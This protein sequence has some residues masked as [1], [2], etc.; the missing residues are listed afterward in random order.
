MTTLQIPAGARPSPVPSIQPDRLAPLIGG[1]WHAAGKSQFEAATVWGALYADPARNG[2]DPS[3]PATLFD[4]LGGLRVFDLRDVGAVATSVSDFTETLRA[5][6]AHL[7]DA[8]GAVWIRIR[9]DALSSLGYRSP[10]D[11]A[12]FRAEPGSAPQ[13]AKLIEGGVFRDVPHPYWAEIWIAECGRFDRL[14]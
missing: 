10:G 14:R 13:W 3:A 8:P 11:L 6:A 1:V 7:F 9:E 2:R 4:L 12:R 5:E